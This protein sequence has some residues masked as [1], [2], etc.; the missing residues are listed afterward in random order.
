M[1]FQARQLRENGAGQA[2]SLSSVIALES[3]FG[4]TRCAPILNKDS[5]KKL[6]DAPRT[7]G[8]ENWSFHLAFQSDAI[9]SDSEGDEPKEGV[10]NDTRNL[11]KGDAIQIWTVLKQC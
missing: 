3:I 5:A 9:L 10:E 7:R 11:A 1:W 8:G 2:G 6:N 4:E